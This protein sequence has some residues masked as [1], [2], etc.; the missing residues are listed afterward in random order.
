MIPKGQNVSAVAL[1]RFTNEKHIFCEGIQ[2]SHVIFIIPD[3]FTVTHGIIKSF[4][5]DF[6]QCFFI[7]SFVYL[8]LPF[9]SYLVTT[10]GIVS[11]H[12]VMVVQEIEIV[13][14]NFF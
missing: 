11:F 4:S 1:R 14:M 5:D 2:N 10:Q 6:L 7:L 13:E 3:L 8:L 12:L 9:Y